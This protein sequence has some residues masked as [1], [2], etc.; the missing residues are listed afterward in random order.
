MYGSGIL[1]YSLF[2]LLTENEPKPQCR[3]FKKKLSKNVNFHH[4]LLLTLESQFW[5]YHYIFYTKIVLFCIVFI[6]SSNLHEENSFK[7]SDVVLKLHL[8]SSA[9]IVDGSDLKQL[10]ENNYSQFFFIFYENFVT[11]ENSL[12]QKG[13]FLSFVGTLI[14]VSVKMSMEKCCLKCCR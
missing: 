8:F 12:K 14:L 6:S 1:T 9:D 13:K 5:E 3:L 7:V 2:I 4:I 10:F 11:L